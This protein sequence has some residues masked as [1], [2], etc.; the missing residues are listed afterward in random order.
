MT[1][2][3]YNGLSAVIG[4]TGLTSS[5]TTITFASRLT[6]AGGT[7]VPTIGA[8]DYIPLAILDASGAL[9]EIVHLTAYTAAATTGTI[10]RAREST[11]AK[12]HNVGMLAVHAPTIVDWIG[13]TSIVRTT[14]TGAPGTVDTYTITYGDGNT[15][16]FQVTN[17]V[18][19]D[20][21]DKGDPGAIN[22]N[23]AIAAKGDLIAG[24][25]PGAA[26]ILPVGTNGQVLT[27]DSSS[28]QGV[29]WAAGG[30]GGG[31][32][33][34]RDRR[35]MVGPG[36]I[37]IDEF[38]DET[39]DPAWVLAAH[40]SVPALPSL[41]RPRYVESGDVLSI[42]YGPDTGTGGGTPD[43]ATGR[44]CAIV[45]PLSGIG[46]SLAVGD[47]I[48]TAVTPLIRGNA[49]YRVTGLVLSTS[50]TSGTGEQLYC[51]WWSGNT[52]IRLLTSWGGDNTAGTD[53][54]YGPFLRS[55]FYQRIVRLSSNAWRYDVS[56]DGVTWILGNTAATWSQE[57]THIGFADGNF[58][59]NA[60]S[61][62][63]YEFI[64]R[65][66]GVS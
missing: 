43:G 16:T 22:V 7:N 33:A 29:K 42:R 10:V 3:R 57:P 44:H 46:G 8:G 56:V 39:I 65:V 14:G 20:K 26:G 61:I 13:I 36:E 41:A 24:E 52:G 6:H 30:G 32:S 66:S 34:V 63:S 25:G 40:A 48:V 64:R 62:A 49:Q 18:K 31:G 53:Y 4:G 60:V 9:R 19:G 11:T 59:T 54:D 5:A 45:R 35:W 47:G 21:G 2:L 15:A 28:P 23:G 17:G 1:R 38:N 55:L 27:A 51:R 12:T 37:S 58:N 50:G